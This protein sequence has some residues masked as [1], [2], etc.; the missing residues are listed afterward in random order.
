GRDVVVGEHTPNELAIEQTAARE[1]GAEERRLVSFAE[2]VDD[3]HLPAAVAQREH[4]VGPDVAGSAG[5]QDQSGQRCLQA[6]TSPARAAG[7]FAPSAA[8][9]DTSG[10]SRSTSAACRQPDA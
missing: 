2:I 10:P 7:S 1:P 3:E 9:R 8:G 4:G 5:D 6:S